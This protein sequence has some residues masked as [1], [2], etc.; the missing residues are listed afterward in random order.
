VNLDEKTNPNDGDVSKVTSKPKK[1]D[2]PNKPSISTDN[3]CDNLIS[4]RG[5]HQWWPLSLFMVIFS[6]KVSENSQ[7]CH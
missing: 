3:Q 4:E 7:E 6:T 1:P 2:K 5:D